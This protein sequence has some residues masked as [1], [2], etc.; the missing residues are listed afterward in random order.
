MQAKKASPTKPSAANVKP[1]RS[2]P[3]GKDEPVASTS[4]QAASRTVFDVSTDDDDDIAENQLDED[5]L[6]VLPDFFAG[7]TFLLSGKFSDRRTLVRYIVAYNGY[8][9][10]LIIVV[11]ICTAVVPHA[12][13]QILQ[14]LSESRCS[15]LTEVHL[16]VNH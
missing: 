4:R 15:R 12:H 14:H 10:L 1:T 8:E 9:T 2:Q 11:C 13:T 7:R 3:D 16:P 6:P 5:G